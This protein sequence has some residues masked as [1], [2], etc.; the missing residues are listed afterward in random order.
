M[1]NYPIKGKYYL[2]KKKE[3]LLFK[4]KCFVFEKL[5]GANSGIYR[6][7]GKTYL[8]KKG[9][10]IDYSHPQYSFFSNQWYWLNKCKIERL[11][12][13]I[14]VYGEL[15]RCVH[16]IKYKNLPDWFIV[17]DI[18]DLKNNKYIEWGKVKKICNKAG[19]STVP[20]IYEGIIKNKEHLEKLVP[21]KSIYGNIIEGIVVKNYNNQVMG[22]YVKSH[23]IKTIEET[24]KHWSKKK[25]ELN[26]VI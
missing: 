22:K 7:N 8:Q 11:P 14:V 25:I 16:T 17:F 3:E 15:L 10:N 19:L 4:G 26:K 24:N 9:S 23:F 2:A 13:N 21:K 20:F 5:D 12:D 6:E 1:P 18:F